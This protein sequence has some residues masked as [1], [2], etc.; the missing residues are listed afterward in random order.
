MPHASSQSSRMRVTPEPDGS[1][2]SAWLAISAGVSTRSL[3]TSASAAIHANRA[4]AT[5]CDSTLPRDERPAMTAKSSSPASTFSSSAAPT[6]TY[7]SSASFG[8][9]FWTAATKRGSHVNADSSPTPK[10]SRPLSPSSRATES[11]SAATDSST[12]TTAGNNASP[13]SVSTARCPLRS[14]SVRSTTCS[15]SLMR[16]DND[17]TDRCSR[18]AAV[19]KFAHVAA[20]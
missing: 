3:P 4:S 20:Q 14:N 5:G 13:S 16:L 1:S 15:S 17:D 19:E 6:S 2:T 10:R 12:R 8:C 11:C 7:G 9:C 18:C